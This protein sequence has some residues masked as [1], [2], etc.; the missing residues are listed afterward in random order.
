M[1]TIPQKYV[2]R[3]FIVLLHSYK[4]SC[5]LPSKIQASSHDLKYL[6]LKID[7]LSAVQEVKP[8]RDFFSL[9]IL[10]EFILQMFIYVFR[11]SFCDGIVSAR[12]LRC[13][14]FLILDEFSLIFNQQGVERNI[15]LSVVKV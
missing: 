9:D 10:I 5:L 13:R 6:K 2:K 14:N 4:I 15:E 8:K 12:H 7:R 11:S 3:S 1:K